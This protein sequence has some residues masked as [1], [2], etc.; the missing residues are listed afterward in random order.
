M[1]GIGG[2]AR[3]LVHAD[4]DYH[5]AGMFDDVCAQFYLN[6]YLL[7]RSIDHSSYHYYSSTVVVH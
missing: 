4:G 2:V 3:H 5:R 7:D 1:G 6:S